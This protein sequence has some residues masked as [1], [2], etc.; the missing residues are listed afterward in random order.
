[1]K[2]EAQN[3]HSME[4]LFSRCHGAYAQ[5]TLRGYRNGLRRFQTWCGERHLSWLPA[6]PKSVAAFVDEVAETMAIATMKHHL[7]AVRFAHR[8]ADLPCPT[9]HSEVRLA[10]RRA[11]RAKSARQDQVLGLTYTMLQKLV[12]AC[13][14]SLS[15]LRDAA[16]LSVGYDTL[17]RSSELDA[18]KNPRL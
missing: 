10:V 3:T 16:L 15:G 12:A 1:M 7:D 9:K 17:C 2:H 8:M 4:K 6:E 13:P 5:N 14:N 11:R 18:S